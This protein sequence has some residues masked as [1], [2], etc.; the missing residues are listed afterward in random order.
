MDEA[1]E[2][3]LIDVRADT[4]GF[5]RDAASLRDMIAG[6]MGEGGRLGGVMIHRALG[7]LLLDGKV[8][9]ERL[10]LGTL[11]Q[12]AEQ[13]VG[14]LVKATGLGGGGGAAI[15]GGGGAGGGGGLD[16][17]ALA[18]GLVRGLIGAPG[19]ATGGPV[20]PGA[21]YRVGEQ[22]AEWFVPASAGRIVPAGEAGAAR[23]VRVEIVV[24]PPAE[25][26]PAALAQSSRQVARAV[27]EALA[28]AER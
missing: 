21:A 26:A 8:D 19:R 9:I 28:A 23:P 16:L 4:Q 24:R 5:A 1:S 14:V 11:R 3:L 6:A 22:G 10:A 15:G 25:T 7:A 18:G 17:L 12:L 13:A 27:A 20:A 2:T